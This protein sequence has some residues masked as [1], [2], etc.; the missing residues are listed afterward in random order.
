[1]RIGVFQ[2]LAPWLDPLLAPLVWLAAQTLKL[3]RRMTPGRARY[4]M[5]VLDKVGVY[6]LIDH[7][8]EPLIN[9]RHL[10][11]PLSQVRRIAGMEYPVKDY[12]GFFEQLSGMAEMRDTPET[13]A[14][15]EHRYHFSASTFGP[16]D[17]TVLY[18]IIR[19]YRPRRIVEIGCGMS[20]L[21]ALRATQRN[22]QDDPAYS[23]R[24]VCVEP[25][26]QPWL[27]TLP[28]TLLRSRLEDVDSSLVE[29]LQ[30]GDI[31]FIDS[32]HVIRPQGDVL[33]GLFDWV[34]RV[35]PG[36]IVH[37]HDILSPRDYPEEWVF[38]HR[39][40]WNEQYLVEAFLAFN[41]SYKVLL[42][43]NHLFTEETEAVLRACP[44]QG[45]KGRAIPTSFWL[46]RVK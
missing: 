45:D 44:A 32:S 8:Y 33:V 25:Y 26:E 22:Q 29:E 6:P 36:V 38:Q 24:H 10:R 42:P 11:K 3:V 43:V 31:L 34:G 13:A 19:R 39:F 35:K 37:I 28:V 20:T 27:E 46:T 40:M 23:C 16:L 18:G 14:P 17:A 15:G 30:A 5:A 2:R 9:L 41:E 21:A 4:C 1:M 12:L 7:Y